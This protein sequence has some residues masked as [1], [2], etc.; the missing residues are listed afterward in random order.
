MR[1]PRGKSG[2]HFD[3]RSEGASRPWSMSVEAMIAVIGF[4]IDAT[5]NG[6]SVVLAAAWPTRRTPNARS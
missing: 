5:A 1:S 2:I 4:V 6:V 3:R